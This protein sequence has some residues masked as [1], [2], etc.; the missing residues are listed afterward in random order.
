[1]RHRVTTIFLIGSL[2]GLSVC[3]AQTSERV[4]SES[5]D[6]ALGYMG[7]ANFLI[8]RIGREC[9]AIVGRPE[10]PQQFVQAWQGRNSR[11]VMA[12]AKYMESRLAEVA[13]TGGEERRNAVLKDMMSRSQ[14][15]A[16]GLLL[17]WYKSGPKEDVCRRAV[18][19]V[20]TGKLDVSPN[21]SIFGDLQALVEWAR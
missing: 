16:D 11:F 17:T 2:V 15:A 3:H 21:V 7:T 19:M 14:S 1:M 12:A 9:L 13:V 18:E 5:R 10:S 6:A 8:G 4:H 20:D